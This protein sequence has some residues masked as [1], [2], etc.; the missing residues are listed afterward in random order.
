[1]RCQP[2]CLQISPRIQI[3]IRLSSQC[4]VSVSAAGSSFLLVPIP[5]HSAGNRRECK[6]KVSGWSDKQTVHP[7]PLR[8]LRPAD[9]TPPPQRMA[10]NRLFFVALSKSPH[11]F[12]CLT[13]STPHNEITA[14]QWLYIG[15]AMQMILFEKC[16]FIT[17]DISEL[18]QRKLIQH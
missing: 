10:E 14:L 9:T 16:W 5:S 17:C 11:S 12:F 15:G 6:H 13:S 7:A 1:M 8:S 2:S 3:H 18:H 4:S